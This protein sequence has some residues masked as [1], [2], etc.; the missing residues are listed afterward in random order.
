[1]N[2]RIYDPDLARFLAADPTIPIVGDLQ[3]YNRYSYVRNNPLKYT[4]P[5]GYSLAR[6]GLG[7]LSGGL[8]EQ[9]ARPIIISASV[10]VASAVVCAGSAG[11]GCGL[12]MVAAGA[13]LQAA[14]ARYSSGGTWSGAFQVGML[15]LMGGM[16][17]FVAGAGAGMAFAQWGSE[18][19][20]ASGVAA[21]AV[22]GA[23]MAP[24]SG[25]S[26]S[27]GFIMGAWMGFYGAAL[28]YAMARAPAISEADVD[29]AARHGLGGKSSHLQADPADGAEES[30]NW[31]LAAKSE[32]GGWIVQKVTASVTVVDG[33]GNSMTFGYSYWEAWQVDPGKAVTEFW[34]RS[35]PDD[36]FQMGSPP[37]RTHGTW[38]IVATAR[39][40][41]GWSLPETFQPM[42]AQPPV[43]LAPAYRTVLPSPDVLLSTTIRPPLPTAGASNAVDRTYFTSW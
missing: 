35:G 16:V 6:W 27:Q 4:D 19:A 14:N 26:F 22:S 41:E 40:Y 15:N 3:S 32:K 38:S 9:W 39:F 37:A 7:I 33:E 29:D 1:M 17:G 8:T 34:G 25:Q 36:T 2:G 20:I 11:S 12:A 31:K 24:A 21:G 42:G 13:A 28:G 18:G 43:Y 10:V 5:T 30:I 23:F